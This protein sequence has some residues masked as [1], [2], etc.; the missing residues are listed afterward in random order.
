MAATSQTST[1]V[2]L[3]GLDDTAVS[4][5]RPPPNYGLDYTRAVQRIR[6]N[7]IKMGDPSGMSIL[8]MFPGLDDWPKYSLSNAAMLNLNQTGGTLEAINK[9]LN[10][11]FKDI[12]ATRS[13]GSRLRNDISVVDASPC[14]GGRGARCDFWRSVAARV[15]M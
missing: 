11:A 3:H 13:I 7:S 6:G 14:E 12:D 10:A 2:A 4:G 9:T 8:D 15:P 5:N 1:P